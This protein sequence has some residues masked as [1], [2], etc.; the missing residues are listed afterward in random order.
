MVMP[1][2]RPGPD[3]ERCLSEAL[4]AEP[5]A[6]EVI[7]VCDG[8]WAAPA[9]AVA[10]HLGARVV[11]VARQRGPAHARNAGARAAK[12]DVLFFVDSDVVVA[13][14]VVGRVEA[15]F[16]ADPSLSAVFGSYDDSPASQDFLSQ[17][18]NLLHHHVHQSAE[19]DATTFWAGGGA[20]ACAVRA[21]SRSSNASMVSPSL[22]SL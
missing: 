20:A 2:H 18:R 7:V 8:P 21:T 12:G 5:A 16:A 17:Y 22:T 15:A 10:A 6:A 14:D 4:A 19:G 13:P 3:F 1:T 11:L 9:A